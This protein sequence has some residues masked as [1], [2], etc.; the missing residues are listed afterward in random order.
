MND[1]ALTIELD[2]SAANSL[3][4]LTD[5]WGVPP[6]EAVL[7]AVRTTAQA[8]APLDSTDRLLVFRR[9]Q[10]AVD[11]TAAKAEKWKDEVRQSRR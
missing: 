6:Q 2:E 11:M 5:R 9:L 8:L 3:R 4:E 1:S 10:A 7:R